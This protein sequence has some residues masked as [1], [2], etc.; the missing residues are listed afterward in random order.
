[1]EEVEELLRRYRPAGPS[2]DLRGRVTA[3]RAGG[4]GAA[5]VREWVLVAA[6]LLCAVFFYTLAAREHQHIA[7]LMPAPTA[8]VSPDPAMEP[9]P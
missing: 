9:W 1:M 2:P 7:R 8:A 4:R 3:L 6:A 5:S